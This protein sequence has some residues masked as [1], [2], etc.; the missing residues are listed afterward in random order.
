MSFCVVASPISFSSFSAFSAFLSLPK[1]TTRI[2][3]IAV[4]KGAEKV[5]QHPGGDARKEILRRGRPVGSN[6]GLG[7]GGD[8]CKETFGPGLIRQGA[9]E[10]FGQ[11]R[12]AGLLAAGPKGGE[13]LLQIIDAGA[14]LPRGGRVETV[15]KPRLAVKPI[16]DARD[17]VGTSE[18]QIKEAFERPGGFRQAEG[19]KIEH[20]VRLG[21]K[22]RLH[23]RQ[24]DRLHVGP[25]LLGVGGFRRGGR[26][27]GGC[28]NARREGHVL[29]FGA[30]QTGGDLHLT[31]LIYMDKT[32]GDALLIFGVRAVESGL[33]IGQ[34][35]L[36]FRVEHTR[37]AHLGKLVVILGLR[38]AQIALDG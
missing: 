7:L 29:V 2:A 32:T 1:A 23:R 24:P 26:A 15:I 37:L 4:E 16:L 34:P 31:R 19:Q 36:A 20:K 30:H 6:I 38:V 8:G 33:Q 13:G 28:K 35:R 17:V 21:Q 12:V 5:G 22:G 18:A 25:Q 3:G 9:R 14:G 11:D 10:S 27:V